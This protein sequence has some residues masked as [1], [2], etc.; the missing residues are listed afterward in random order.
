MTTL[1]TIFIDVTTALGQSEMDQAEMA[2]AAAMIMLDQARH[3]SPTL[4]AYAGI[5]LRK[6]FKTATALAGNDLPR[7]ADEAVEAEA[8]GALTLLH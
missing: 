6:L 3:V 2:H 5:A 1:T 7:A 4:A 8:Y